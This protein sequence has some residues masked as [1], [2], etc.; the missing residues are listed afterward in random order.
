MNI[1]VTITICLGMLFAAY[2]L[3]RIH[4]QTRDESRMV[5]A[6]LGADAFLDVP[7]APPDIVQAQ[8]LEAAIEVVGYLDVATGPIVTPAPAELAIPAPLVID[9]GDVPLLAARAER[10]HWREKA[11]RADR[12]R[13]RYLRLLRV[14]RARLRYMLGDVMD[15][16]RRPRKLSLVEVRLDLPGTRRHLSLVPP[17]KAR[18]WRL[19][20]AA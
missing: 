5:A 6:G 15:A 3:G 12:L 9:L 1:T 20:L 14:E 18:E 10:D 4:Q 19:A 13:A 8:A 17:L 2:L 16:P 11:L 7:V